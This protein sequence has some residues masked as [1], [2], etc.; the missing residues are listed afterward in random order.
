MDFILKYVFLRDFTF[1]NKLTPYL[2]VILEEV[3]Y[4]KNDDYRIMYILI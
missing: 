1:S 4:T 2:Q 3:L